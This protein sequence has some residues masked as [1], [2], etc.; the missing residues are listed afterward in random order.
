MSRFIPID[1]GRFA[2]LGRGYDY[3]VELSGDDLR[4]V[5]VRIIEDKPI[6]K[7]VRTRYDPE[8]TVFGDDNA[9]MDVFLGYNIKDL[10]RTFRDLIFSLFMPFIV[11]FYCLVLVFVHKVPRGFLP[12]W[13]AYLLFPLL[14]MLGLYGYYRMNIPLLAEFLKARDLKKVLKKE[15]FKQC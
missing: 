13:S 3:I 9:E 14:G 11:G 4:D 5:R 8:I 2:R 10:N 7:R 12:F 15:G 6:I 1:K